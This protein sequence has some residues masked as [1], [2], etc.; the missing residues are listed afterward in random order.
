MARSRTSRKSPPVAPRNGHAR[1]TES[2]VPILHR[3]RQLAKRLDLS[4]QAV[5]GLIARGQLEA[6]RVAGRWRIPEASVLEYLRRCT[7]RG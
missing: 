4:R 6:F 7:V 2:A 5:Y 3:P 1:P